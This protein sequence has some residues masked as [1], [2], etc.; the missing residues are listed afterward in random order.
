MRPRGHWAVGSFEW[1]RWKPPTKPPFFLKVGGVMTQSL[2][3]PSQLSRRSL[4]RGAAVGAGV[5]AV[6]GLLAACSGGGGGS[7]S[8]G[9]AQQTITFGAN[10]SDDIPKKAIAAMVAAYQTKN[11]K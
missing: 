11:G 7:G 10:Y 9:A 5:V 2:L 4:L 6:P 1:F 3:T 8:S